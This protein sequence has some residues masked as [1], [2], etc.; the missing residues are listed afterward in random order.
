MVFIT[1]SADTT[2][3]AHS[4]TL[5]IALHSDLLAHSIMMLHADWSKITMLGK[6]RVYTKGF[7]HFQSDCDIHPYKTQSYS[8]N[9][10][11]P[12]MLWKYPEVLPEISNHMVKWSIYELAPLVPLHDRA[13]REPYFA[14]YVVWTKMVND[15]YYGKFY[16]INKKY[17]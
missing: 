3:L 7:M 1:K 14:S 10:V 12:T 6:P 13:T 5:V 15:H 16:D 9:L 8:S 2:T 17:L 11:N 4:Q